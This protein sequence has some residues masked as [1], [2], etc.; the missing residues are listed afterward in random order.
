MSSLLVPWC[1]HMPISVCV[2]PND[3]AR[4]SS[5]DDRASRKDLRADQRQP[6]KPVEAGGGQLDSGFGS[7]RADKICEAK[8]GRSAIGFISFAIESTV[9]VAAFKQRCEG[10]S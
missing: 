3:P 10:A 2:K 8:G 9:R 6:G 1:H 7:L 5:D 4:I